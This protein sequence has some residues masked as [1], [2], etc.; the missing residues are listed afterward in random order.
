MKEKKSLSR[1][2]FANRPKAG[3]YELQPLT[4]GRILFLEERGNSLFTGALKE[5]DDVSS[6]DVYEAFFVCVCSGEELAE[7]ASGDE[8]EKAVKTFQ[9]DLQDEALVDFWNV[10][11][12]EQES[13]QKAKAVPKKKRG[14]KA[15]RS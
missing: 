12:E 10:L 13:I 5:G 11:E 6:G 8:F 7:L 9:F 2:L 14:R 4:A 1:T 15:T 3:G